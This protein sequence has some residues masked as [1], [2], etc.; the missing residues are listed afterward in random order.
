MRSC[1]HPCSSHSRMAPASS[2]TDLAHPSI[3]R[4][5]GRRSFMNNIEITPSAR[6]TNPLDARTFRLLTQGRDSESGGIST[7]PPVPVVLEEDGQPTRIAVAT[8]TCTSKLKL[9]NERP[10]PTNSSS[11]RNSRTAVEIN[12]STLLSEVPATSE[13]HRRDRRQNQNV[14]RERRRGTAQNR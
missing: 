2:R 3:V 12:A 14:S 11:P 9:R 13:G 1:A 7:F 6:H 8:S 10:W 4:K 5:A